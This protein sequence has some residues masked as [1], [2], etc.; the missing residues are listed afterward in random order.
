[1]KT[2][3]THIHKHLYTYTA[4]YKRQS[5]RSNANIMKTTHLVPIAHS[6]TPMNSIYQFKNSGTFFLVE[7]EK[8][9][10]N[11]VVRSHIKQKLYKTRKQRGCRL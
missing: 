5:N 4:I 11:R 10:Y 3:Y 8:S 7:H 6:P 2:K 1:M 9:D